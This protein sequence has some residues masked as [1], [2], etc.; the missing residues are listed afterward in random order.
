MQNHTGE[1]IVSG[2][3][4]RLFGFSNVGF[5]LGSEDVTLDIDGELTRADLDRVEAIANRAVW[6]NRPV[7]CGYP[8]AK[9]L[10]QMSYR[11]KLEL[12]E[13][14][15]IVTVEGYDVCAC[16]APHV[17]ATGEIGVI[18]LLDFLRYKGGTRIH[19][20]C[21]AS[22]LAD[23]GKKYQNACRISNTLSVKQNEVA[24]GV[25]R[26]ADELFGAQRALGEAKRQILT[27]RGKT[28]PFSEG[29]LC[30]FESD[31]DPVFLR[32]LANL[33]ADHCGGICTVF[34][35]RDGGYRY[36]AASRHLDLRPFAKRLHASCNGRGGGSAELVQGSVSTTRKE[37]EAFLASDKEA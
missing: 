23:Y 4:Y 9:E 35:G 11:S 28:M 1:H 3:I 22:A 24:E 36:F 10:A 12:T 37:L 17:S 16:C 34:F 13:N 19:M 5:H 8:S 20:L 27:L 6:E 21:G 15:R 32:E 26:M 2:I 31:T 33:G 7:T 14:V 25:M 18:K 29:N 30:F